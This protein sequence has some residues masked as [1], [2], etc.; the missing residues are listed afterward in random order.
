[1]KPVRYR[2]CLMAATLRRVSKRLL[3]TA[4]PVDGR[5]SPSFLRGCRSHARALHPY[6]PALYSSHLMRAS[7]G[8]APR[9]YEVRQECEIDEEHKIR[10]VKSPQKVDPMIAW[11]VSAP[12]AAS[13]STPR[14]DLS[15][16]LDSLSLVKQLIKVLSRRRCQ[17]SNGVE[18]HGRIA[19]RYDRRPSGRMS[20][21]VMMC[22]GRD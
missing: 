20:T 7:P 11:Q 21:S 22:G 9:R 8:R 16:M 4:A 10:D 2:A 14:F 13:Q 5:I 19:V 6:Q 18:E 12:L 17:V 3:N 1:M 15:L